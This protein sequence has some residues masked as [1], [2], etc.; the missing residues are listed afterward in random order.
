MTQNGVPSLGWTIWAIWIGGMLAG[1]F[2]LFLV[3]SPEASAGLMNFL[4]PIEPRQ[5]T[6]VTWTMWTVAKLRYYPL[7]FIVAGQLMYLSRH[8]GPP[9]QFATFFHG[10]VL[11][12]GA[13]LLLAVYWLSLSMFT[14]GGLGSALFVLVPALITTLA[15]AAYLKIM[16]V[17]FA[18]AGGTE[19]A[20][21]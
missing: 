14:Q 9:S 19:N 6:E 10:I 7:L 21:S 2:M 5:E 13:A 1:L 17:R 3:P 4:N 18:Q 12:I 8:K 20:L 11:L 15:W 16:R